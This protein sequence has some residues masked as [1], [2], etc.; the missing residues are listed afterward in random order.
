MKYSKRS[1]DRKIGIL[2]SG[3]G[4]PEMA[5]SSV[6]AVAMH[7]VTEVSST[8]HASP[9]M[10]AIVMNSTANTSCTCLLPFYI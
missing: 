5:M 6:G 9:E 7:V 1:L 4:S 10:D 3:I 8:T 2:P